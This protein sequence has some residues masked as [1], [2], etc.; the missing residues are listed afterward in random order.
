[1]SVALLFPPVVDPRAPHLALP[2]LAAALRARGEEVRVYDCN[3]AGLR[4]LLDGERLGAAGR[5][6]RERQGAQLDLTTHEGLLALYARHV[7]RRIDDALQVF[8][9][10]E[11]FFDPHAFNAA[12]ELVVA[13]LAIAA[14]A[15]HP[16]LRCD[17]M[18]PRYDVEG[19]DA[20]RL[21]DLVRV[22]GSTDFNLFAA[23]WEDWLYPALAAQAPELVGIT[24]TNR[25]QLLPGLMLARGLRERG[26][27]VVIGGTVF[28]K[29]TTELRARPAFF[30]HF[31][32]ALV[33]Y[34]GEGALL[35]LLAERRGEQRYARVPNLLFLDGEQVRATPT[36]V[37]D[38]DALPTPDFT[39]LDLPT[40][41]APHPVL[42]ILTGKGCYFN[43]CKFCDIPYI[44]H[45]SRKAYRLRDVA[46]IVADI[47]DLEARF[48]CRHFVITDEALSPKLLVKLAEA[49]APLRERGYAFTGYARL[50]EG[51]TPEACR[52]IAGMG[53][54]KLYFGLESADQATLDHMDKGTDATVAATVLANCAAAGIN[55]HLFSIVGFPGESEAAAQVTCDFL[56]DQGELID[57]PGNT[58]D[59]HPFGLEL[60]T[61]YFREREAHAI[62]FAPGVL[63]ADFVIGLD[64]YQWRDPAGLGGAEV[65]RLLGQV[66]YPRLRDR[67]RRFHASRDGVFPGFE[68][69]AGLYAAH[70]ATRPF[71]CYTSLTAAGLRFPLQLGWNAAVAVIRHAE[72]VLLLQQHGF[73][74]LEGRLFDALRDLRLDADF[75]A[76]DELPF[77][78]GLSRADRLAQLDHLVASRYLDVSAVAAA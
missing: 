22:A 1:M 65:D 21:D 51:F 24:I 39:G 59:M 7:A 77:A 62:E 76:V 47:Q 38:I 31:A 66:F 34:E 23:H 17:I 61:D 9:D 69:Y 25:Q 19:C 64:R 73:Q 20:R 54:K 8:D 55:F 29:F 40:Y 75:A 18:P 5:V 72:Q 32:D 56:L 4:W 14:S 45:I 53:M 42:P 13:G 48:G 6:L 74:R 71:T 63:D 50:E 46:R 10:P 33:A 11:R 27:F 2:S 60:R 44:N 43:R 41:L 26:H 16:Q 67:Y 52:A 15:H 70:Y 12:R 3:V 68:E 58:F 37:E 28:T 30:R 49:L 36:R 78:A 57:R 35:A